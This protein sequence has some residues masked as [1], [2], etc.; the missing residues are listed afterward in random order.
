MSATTREALTAAPAGV[1]RYTVLLTP[2]LEDGG[3]SVAVPALP[4]CRTQ[5]DTLQE[6]LA[7]A[8]EAIQL[9]LEDVIADGEP[10]PE[11]RAQPQLVQVE[12]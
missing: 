1:R 7:N 9:Y 4:G 3:Y 5:G 10:V 6:A 11:E 8:R 2:E 12:V